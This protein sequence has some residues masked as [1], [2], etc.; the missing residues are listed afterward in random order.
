MGFRLR[1]AARTL[2][3]PLLLLA[4]L[5]T[6][7]GC[8][9]RD[10]RPGLWLEGEL[11]AFPDDW[12]FSDAHR[13]IALQVRTP[14]Q[15]PHAVTIWCASLDGEL[16]VAARNPDE[17]RWPGWVEKQ[18]TVRLRVG[19]QL[20]PGR[21]VRLDDPARIADV[22]AAYAAKYELPA[23]APGEGP[24]MRYWRVQAPDA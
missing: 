21:L 8:E 15:L 13:E 12:G 24:P 7:V 5:L 2:A 14:Y 18:P 9:P 17:K 4:A 16:Y 3:G 1:P 22:R 10:Q 23:R 6:A 20:Y 19:E 11:R